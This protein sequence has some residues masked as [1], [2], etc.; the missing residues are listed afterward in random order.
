MAPA[1][2]QSAVLA[3]LRDADASS[4]KG[5]LENAATTLERA[6][7][8]QSR[9]AGLWLRLADVRLRQQQPGL[10]E[11][12]ARKALTL[13]RGAPDVARDSWLLIAEARRRQGDD[14]G[15]AEAEQRAAE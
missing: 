2:G 3:L 12:L 7:R 1:R 10:A 11:D 13:A 14:A 15:A 6:I 4:K 8:I 9:N 5:D